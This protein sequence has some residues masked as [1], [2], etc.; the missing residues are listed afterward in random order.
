MQSIWINLQAEIEPILT[1]SGEIRDLNKGQ[2][3][4]LNGIM[5]KIIKGF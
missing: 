3:K 4:E 5:D 2:T 1:Y